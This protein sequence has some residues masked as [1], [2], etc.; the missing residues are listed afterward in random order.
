M[1]ETV[2]IKEVML[3]NARNI[4]PP[5]L[6]MSVVLGFFNATE[7][8][9]NA[10]LPKITLSFSIALLGCFFGLIALFSGLL[11]TNKTQSILNGWLAGLV[12]GL[13]GIAFMLWFYATPVN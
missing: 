9:I 7:W 6:G 13:A 3:R 8:T 5:M 2:N 4:L 1:S 11:I 12:V 10:I